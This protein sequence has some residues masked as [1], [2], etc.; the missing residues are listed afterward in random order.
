[1]SIKVVVLPLS[2]DT[3]LDTRDI[4]ARLFSF[5]FYDT[6]LISIEARQ[7]KLQKFLS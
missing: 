6:C 2:R 1:M 7:C 3:S 5:W 4:H